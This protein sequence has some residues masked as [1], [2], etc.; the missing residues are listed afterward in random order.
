MVF[1]TSPHVWGPSFASRTDLE[2]DLVLETLEKIAS[3]KLECESYL[4]LLPVNT[5][6]FLTCIQLSL[7]HNASPHLTP[8]RG[9]AATLEVPDVDGSAHSKPGY[10]FPPGHILSIEINI[11]ELQQ[12]PFPSDLKVW[13]VAHA[14]VA[15]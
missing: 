5:D 9:L 14:P 2:E 4:R 13:L 7:H 1:Y 12:S 3:A 8:F 11:A 15:L 10:A 6:H